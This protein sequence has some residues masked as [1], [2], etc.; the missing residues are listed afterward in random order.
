MKHKFVTP[1]SMPCTQEQAEQISLKLKELGYVHDGF[2]WADYSAIYTLPDGIY[3]YADMGSL[4]LSCKGMN[5]LEAYNLKLFLALGAMTDKPEGIYGEWFVQESTGN[6]LMSVHGI[7][8][9][10]FR[11]ATSEELIEHF[12]KK[13]ESAGEEWNVTGHVTTRTCQS[14]KENP[15]QLYRLK[16]HVKKYIQNIPM[17]DINYH[18][19]TLFE[20]DAPIKCWQS[21][22]YTKE[23][24][25]P[26]ESRIKIDIVNYVELLKMED[27]EISHW[28]E[29]ERKNIEHFV[30]GEYSNISEL[31]DFKRWLNFIAHHR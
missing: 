9:D 28:T 15:N 8:S 27:S 20:V 1:V 24:L 11:K 10:G 4:A 26:V 25:E 6:L 12:S 30:N 2:P 23:G 5:K 21:W 16:E 17:Y 29:E 13:E 19:K 22:G 14:K 31:V 3:G 7:V 18:D